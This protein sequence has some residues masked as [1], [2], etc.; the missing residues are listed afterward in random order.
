MIPP[1][2]IFAAGFGTRMG[3]LTRTRPKPMIPVAGQ[4]LIDRA[5]DLAAQVGF[6]RIVVNTHYLADVI[7]DHL[8]GRD[9]TILREVPE[10]LDTGGGLKQALTQVNSPVFATL[11]PDVVWAGPNPLTGLLD[12]WDPARMDGLLACVPLA[13]TLGRQGGGDFSVSPEGRIT[14]KGDMVYGG[15]QIIRTDVLSEIDETVFSLNLAWDRIIA[16]NRLYAGQYGGKW[17]DVGT[18]EGIALAEGMI[19][20]HV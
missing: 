11:N 4:P 12:Q 10:I 1:L 5:L 19:A 6:T 16:K 18:P 2:M 7:E 3:E 13:Q 14:R 20:T 8:A 17:C 9:L 15:A